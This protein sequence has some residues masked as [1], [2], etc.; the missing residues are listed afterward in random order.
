TVNFAVADTAPNVAYKVLTVNAVK[1]VA[2]TPDSINVIGTGAITSYALKAGNTL[3]T[4]LS[5]NTSN[6]IISGTATVVV[7]KSD[8]I[9]ATGPG[10]TGEATVN[11]AVADT[12][13]NVA[14]KV[15]TVNAVKNVAI[16]P[17]SIN[18]IGTGAITSYA[19]KAGN[20]LPTGLSLNTSNGIIS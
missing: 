12:A 10:G 18:V 17:D 16:T 4:G 15:L 1:N 9:V 8:T 7:S 14:Y 13:P 19:L 6:G 11:F 3:P 20:T 2:I 5:L